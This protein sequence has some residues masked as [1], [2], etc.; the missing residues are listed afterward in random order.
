M[1]RAYF[2]IA[3]GSPSADP[4][5]AMVQVVS[6]LASLG[7]VGWGALESQAHPLELQILHFCQQVQQPV[8]LLPLFLLPGNHVAVDVPKALAAAEAIAPFPLHCLPFLGSQPRFQVWLQQQLV[9]AKADILVGHGSRR[10]AVL[11]WFQQLCESLGVLPALLSDPESLSNALK[12]RQAL[13]YAHS[14]L[15]GYFLF[16]GK[17]VD[18]F[19][20]QVQQ[21]QTEY[22]Q[23]RL[24]VTPAIAPTPEFIA[25]IAAILA[26]DVVS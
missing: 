3:H 1:S 11:P 14:H 18:A 26:Q 6:H 17:T 7:K 23:Q 24:S 12:Q 5:Q 10:H 9:N 8:V 15:F 20:A 2:L 21:R 22:P 25:T 19:A 16:G 13:G 4:Q